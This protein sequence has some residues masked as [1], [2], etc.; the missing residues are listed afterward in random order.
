M[1]L[2]GHEKVTELSHRTLCIANGLLHYG[3]TGLRLFDRSLKCLAL[4][5]DDHK[6]LLADPL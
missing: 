1:L 4:F 3:D 6:K 5:R 2:F